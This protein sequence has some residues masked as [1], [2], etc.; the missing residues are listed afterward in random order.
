MKKR[1]V[2]GYLLSLIAGILM[3]GIL[4]A[5]P[6]VSQGKRRQEKG[7]HEQIIYIPYDKLETVFEKQG[8]GVFV[9][10][11]KFQELWTLSR[12]KQAKKEQTEKKKNLIIEIDSKVKILEDVVVVKS[13][14]LLEIQKKGWHQ[15]PLRLDHSAI[16]KATIANDSARILYDKSTGYSLVYNKKS[17]TPEKVSLNLSYTKSY[18]KKAGLNNVQF[19]AP[20]APIRRY[21]VFIKEPGIQIKLTPSLAV[22]QKPGSS[23]DNVTNIIAFA[24]AGSNINIE[25]TPKAEGAKGLKALVSS[26]ILQEEY[27]EEGIIK[28]KAFFSYHITR[29]KLSELN[30]ELPL[31]QR[32]VNVKDPNIKEWSVKRNDKNQHITIH[33]FEPIIGKQKI[34]VDLEK[35]LTDKEQASLSIPVLK[36]LSANRQQGIVA[37]KIS[38]DLRADIKQKSRILQIGHS[39]LPVSIKHKDWNYSF[40]YSSAPFDLKLKLEKLK[41]QITAESLAEISILTDHI[42]TDYT[43]VFNIRKTGVFTLYLK[44]PKDCKIQQLSGIKTGKAAPLAINNYFV[45]KDNSLK[46][47]LSRKAIGLNA[48]RI[49]LKKEYDNSKPLNVPGKLANLSLVIPNLSFKNVERSNNN[50]ILYAPDSIRITPQKSQGLLSVSFKDASKQLGRAQKS[51]KKAILSYAYNLNP[52]QLNITAERRKA[53]ITVCQILEAKLETGVIKYKSSF[54]YDILY[55]G[56]KSLKLN[57][58]AEISDLINIDT[59][60]IQRQVFNNNK[61]NVTWELSRDTEFIGKEKITLSWEQTIDNLDIGKSIDFVLPKLNPLDVNRSWGQIILAKTESI[62]ISPTIKRK[63]LRAIDPH[64]DL[65]EQANVKNAARAFE[66]NDDW[67]LTVKATRYESENVKSTSIE[68]ALLRFVVT[69]SDETSVQ[70]IYRMRSNQQRLVIQLDGDVSFDTQPLRLNDRPISLEKGN[71]NNFY[72]PLTGISA[73]EPFILELRYTITGEKLVVKP[74]S[75][76][77]EPAIQQVFLSIYLPE[78]LRFISSS[79]PWSEESVWAMSRFSIVANVNR[80]ESN[81]LS[82][83][84]GQCKINTDTF[85]SFPTDGVR[86]LFSSLRPSGGTSSILYV[87]AMSSWWL[88]LLVL[89]VILTTGLILLKYP[90]TIRS[91]VVGAIVV[92]L[93]STGI[94]VPS[95]VWCLFSTTSFLAVFIV[96]IIWGVSFL[97]KRNKSLPKKTKKQDKAPPKQQ[98][99]TTVQN[100]T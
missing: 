63:G 32:V 69:R 42:Q 37:I 47:S 67:H 73:D 46:I 97:F 81:L 15:I 45:E 89:L 24:G 54:Y 23:A 17:S 85:N 83:V 55:S 86:Y 56:V 38:P 2:C 30:I 28:T 62:D 39:D 64:H 70:A 20:Y 66:F 18:H 11:E 12:Q 25:W 29:T 44:L 77:H 60:K 21:D 100:V 19:N 41:A 92:I 53:K 33:L 3:V 99:K 35:F 82:T 1:G 48:L 93:I 68:S 52:A 13:T 96:A 72:I 71:K 95:A 8:R 98:S 22:S 31:D 34:Q 43:V 49:S 61:N 76:P 90:Y 58:P 36:D 14:L 6:V 79:G 5:E 26:D 7:Y 16:I 65:L 91:L 59:P 94:F 27:I 50:V 88:K 9:P 87:S 75:F 80:S 74:P 51:D 57:V 78:N 10:Y 4:N 40:Q 84:A